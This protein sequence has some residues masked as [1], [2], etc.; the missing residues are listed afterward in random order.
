MKKTSLRQNVKNENR[1]WFVVDANGKNLGKLAVEIA[2]ILRGKNRVD[3]TPHVDGG[4]FVIVLNSEKI[5]VSGQKEAQKKYYRH[6]GFIGNLK[7]ENLAAVRKKNPVRILHDA[8]SGMLAKNRHR[9][10]Q[11]RRFF[12]IIGE[13]NPHA[14]QKPEILKF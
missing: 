9:K 13:K 8:V 6:S 12:C 10:N 7:T 5:A 3:F 2:K 11:L 1:K 4:D 14:A